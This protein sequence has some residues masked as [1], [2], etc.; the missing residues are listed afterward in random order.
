M[1]LDQVLSSAETL[2]RDEQE[3][4]EDLLR[5]TQN[6]LSIRTVSGAPAYLMA[7]S[8]AWPTR[9][10]ALACRSAG[11]GDKRLGGLEKN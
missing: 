7:G 6:T 11:S 8:I 9:P 4:L 10:V 1:T 2:P 5:K 3:I